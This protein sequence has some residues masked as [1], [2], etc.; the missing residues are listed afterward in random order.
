MSSRALL[1]SLAAF[2]LSVS[3]IAGC[4][5]SG[6]EMRPPGAAGLAPPPP[7]TGEEVVSVPVHGYVWVMGHYH[8]D[9]LSWQWRLGRLL[10]ACPGRY[11][12]QPRYDGHDRTFRPGHW[13]TGRPPASARRGPAPPMGVLQPSRDGARCGG[14]T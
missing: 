14:P 12:V 11:F 5:L 3:T 1:L 4:A 9:G 10:A 7:P 6:A 8:W 2:V 13:R